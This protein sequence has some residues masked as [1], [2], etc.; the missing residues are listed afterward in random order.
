VLGVTNPKGSYNPRDSLE[1]NT[2]LSGPLLSRFDLVM[3][4][5]DAQGADWDATV[6]EHILS[7]HQGHDT[8]HHQSPDKCSDTCSKV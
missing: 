1:V 5:R 7:G 6:S 4:L 8:L 2:G 3:V